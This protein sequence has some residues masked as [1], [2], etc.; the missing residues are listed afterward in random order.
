MKQ[1]INT[2]TEYREAL[3]KLETLMLANP[4]EGSVEADELN[5]LVYLISSY[6][7]HSLITPPHQ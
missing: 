3:E 1:L 5:L 6:E 4:E 2:E 7:R